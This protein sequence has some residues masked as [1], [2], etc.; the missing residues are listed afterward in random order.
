MPQAIFAEL[1]AE[2]L[3]PSF[4][5]EQI[6]LSDAAELTE[7]V[8]VKPVGVTQG[9]DFFHPDVDGESVQMVQSE[10]RDA[11][12]DFSCDAAAMMQSFPRFLSVR[13]GEGGKIE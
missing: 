8:D 4:I 7:G 1:T 2:P 5:V 11:S 12:C 6:L 10:Q 9:E 3:I 13:G